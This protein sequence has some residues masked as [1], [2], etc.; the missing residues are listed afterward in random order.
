MSCNGPVRSVFRRASG[1]PFFFLLLVTACYR[2]GG[3]EPGRQPTY[4]VP[5][6]A[7]GPVRVDI[8]VMVDNSG[9][10]AQEQTALT[11]AFPALVRDLVDPR[12]DDGDGRP[13][14]APVEDLHLG[15]ISSDMGTM[16]SPV[17]TCSNPDVGD[18]G[19]FRSTPSP[20]VSGCLA[21]YP[22]FLA[23]DASNAATYDADQLAQDF[24]CIATLGTSGCGFE[25][26]LE[27]M[28]VAVTTDMRPGGCNDGF[29]RPDS[30]LV[31]IWVTDEDDCS[32]SPDHPEM[33]DQDRT[34]LGH[35][36]LR[37]FLH[38]DFLDTFS[39]YVEAFAALRPSTPE[40]LVVAMITGVPPDEPLCIGRGDDL[41]GCLSVTRMIPTIDPVMP[42]QLIPSCN[43]SMGLAFPPTRLV[44]VA[45]AFGS[46][47]YVDSICQ[48]DWSG[49]MR[50]ING[51]LEQS[52]AHPCF[53]EPLSFDPATCRSSCVLVE[54]L[55]DDRPC[56]AD[57]SCPSDGCPA[58]SPDD[59]PDL[60]P[61]RG[62]EP[63]STCAPLK[64]DLGLVVAEDGRR[65][66]RCLVHQATRDP[67]DGDCSAPLEE[68]WFYVPEELRTPACP[69]L[70]LERTGGG[71]L[72]DE[73][74]AAEFLCYD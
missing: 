9:S 1:T 59:L 46:Q 41:A 31:L 42:V 44:E 43:T 63:G 51:I 6:T 8:V 3:D 71:S 2:S 5:V 7:P 65:L 61:C 53:A 37:C 30:I 72:L 67:A 20:V 17:S 40:K 73:G 45:Q 62:T 10:M 11:A 55:S 29:L 54:T 56:E 14:H 35:L 19:C 38:P 57:E 64:R 34:D 21:T 15:V 23:R 70:V 18:N 69:E 22:T 26:Q 24:T 48:S 28:R 58:A 36:S 13:D 12:D 32:T 49:P 27:A 66:R 47:A 52:I 4:T 60:T 39:S 16:G 68:G 74:S 33:F 25:Q 50:G